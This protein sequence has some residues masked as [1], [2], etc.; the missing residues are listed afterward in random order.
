MVDAGA[1]TGAGGDAESVSDAGGWMFGGI[2][3]DE[4]ADYVVGLDGDDHGGE[5]GSAWDRRV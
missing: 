5:S 4:S 1:A 2:A 3:F